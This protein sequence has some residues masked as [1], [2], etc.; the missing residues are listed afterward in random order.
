MT[1]E[2][3]AEGL[4]TLSSPVGD[5]PHVER[6]SFAAA[7]VSTAL[8]EF[9]M[10]ATLVG[11]GAIE[12]YAPES[13]ATSDIDLV[14]ERSTREKLND[15][16]S[17]LG[18]KKIARHWCIGDIVVEVPNDDLEDPFEVFSVGE[19]QLRVIRRE[20]V[21][22]ERVIGYRYWKTWAYGIQA[23]EM[24]KAFGATVDPD[25]LRKRLRM[26]QAEEAYELLV[27][28]AE[29]GEVVDSEK[30][31]ELWYLHYGHR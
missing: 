14:V 4:R 5:M 13:Y 26:D 28:I 24:I 1:I 27:S 21:L 22:A 16:F 20:I 7:L 9:G 8:A 31:Q 18:M 25:V 2:E 12:F 17:R 6:L 23:I 3:I 15:V 29:S 10:R 30:L 11:G 19:F